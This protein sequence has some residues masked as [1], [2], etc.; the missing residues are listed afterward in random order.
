MVKSHM[1][2]RENEG[3]E[4]HEFWVEEGERRIARIRCFSSEKLFP[5]V[6]YVLL[7]QFLK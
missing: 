3:C 1:K 2:S 7:D 6:N 4:G 5:V